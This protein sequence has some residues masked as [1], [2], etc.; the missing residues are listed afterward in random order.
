MAV[1]AAVRILVVDDFVLWRT[2]VAIK[3]GEN[4]AFGIVGIA[5]DG[6]AAVRKAAELQPDLI[7]MD[8]NLPSLSGII[9]ARKI[10]DLSLQSKILFV[11]QNLDLDIV[12]AALD[13]GGLG[14]VAKS[15]AE[16]ELLTS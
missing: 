6:S 16:S 14:Y 4:P 11:S 2:Y 1:N 3:L 5:S 8:I 9:A 12:R 7:L 10:R 13:A 15:A